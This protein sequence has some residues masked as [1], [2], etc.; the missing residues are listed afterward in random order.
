MG[1]IPVKPT[2]GVPALK[3]AQQ[4]KVDIGG[5]RAAQ[6]AAQFGEARVVLSFGAR[7]GGANF[8]RWLRWQIIQQRGYGKPN[9]VYLDTVALAEVPETKIA[10]VDPRRPWLTGVASYNGGWR[11][12]YRNAILQAHTMIFV[13]TEPWSNSVYCRG[14]Y[15]YFVYEARRRRTEGRPP[16]NGLVV[17][18]SDCK[19]PFPG[20]PSIAAEREYAD[21]GFDDSWQVNGTVLLRLMSA[22]GRP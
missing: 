9:N 14:E 12:Y 18:F 15:D 20:L 7:E 10:V 6:V 11:A 16:L 4:V 13:G 3:K 19:E 5:A 17:R 22:I 1:W 8:A 2:T 21:V